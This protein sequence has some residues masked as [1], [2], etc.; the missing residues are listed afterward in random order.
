MF[1]EKSLSPSNMSHVIDRQLSR[2]H[3]GGV[4]TCMHA[5]PLEIRGYGLT[6]GKAGVLA[7]ISEPY[8]SILHLTE[9]PEPSREGGRERNGGKELHGDAVLRFDD[10]GRRLCGESGSIYALACH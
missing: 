4:F 9:V 10:A 7:T 2:D 8:T 6:F 5:K 3:N 1:I